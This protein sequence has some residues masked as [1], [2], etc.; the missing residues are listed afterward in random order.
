MS[1]ATEFLLW[2]GRKKKAEGITL[3]SSGRASQTSLSYLVVHIKIH[4]NTCK[5]KKK[6]TATV[7]RFLR[8]QFCK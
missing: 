2:R 1:A 3:R 8:K 7:I 6:K 4:V 5:K